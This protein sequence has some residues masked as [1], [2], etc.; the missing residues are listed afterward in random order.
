ML[1]VTVSVTDRYNHHYKW[2]LIWI[3]EDRV[4]I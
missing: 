4:E 3:Y 2:Y 1:M